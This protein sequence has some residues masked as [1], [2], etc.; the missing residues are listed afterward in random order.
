MPICDTRVTFNTERSVL[1]AIR[2]TTREKMDR[3]KET[4]QAKAAP[5]CEKK[6]KK[7]NGIVLEKQAMF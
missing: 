1:R 7:K 6:Q 5:S 3:H 2:D 4:D